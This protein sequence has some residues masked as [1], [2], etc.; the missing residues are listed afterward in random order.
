M[1]IGFNQSKGSAQKDRADS[2]AYQD[3]ENRVRLVGDLLARYVYWVEGENKKQLPF[4]CLA[5]NRATEKFDN[6]E[7]DHV[8]EFYPDLK[9]TWAYAIQC[10]DLRTGELKILNLKKKL[11]AQM[12]EVADQ[13]ELDPTDPETGFD[14]IFVKK[15]TGPLP[16]NVEYTVQ[17]IKC[18]QRSLTE[19]ERELVAS[20]KSMDEV[21]PRPTADAQKALL[22][23]LQSGAT[24]NVDESIEGEFDVK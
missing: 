19:K 7:V 16:I 8:K 6:A 11:M 22:Q 2:Y 17:Q 24:E 15:K 9:C 13:L 12:M 21:L 20:L 4:E 14:I 5:F 10:I 23:K 1:A 18:K 3:G